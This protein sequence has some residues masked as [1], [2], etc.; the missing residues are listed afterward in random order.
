MHFTIWINTLY[1]SRNLTT[2]T[3]HFVILIRW[4][5]QSQDVSVT[6]PDVDIESLEMQFEL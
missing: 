2:W 5:R 3:K 6:V 4:S 1:A